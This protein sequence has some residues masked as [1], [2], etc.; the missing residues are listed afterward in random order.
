MLR[1]ALCGLAIGCS[2]LLWNDGDEP[3]KS[4]S[5]EKKSTQNN[6]EKSAAKLDGKKLS[7]DEQ[8]EAWLK[9][10]PV[11]ENPKGKLKQS[12]ALNALNRFQSQVLNSKAT[13]RA[14]TGEYWD[15]HGDGT[16]VCRRCNAPLYR[17]KDKFDSRCGWPSFDD[18]LPGLVTRIPDKDGLRIE[19]VCTNCGGHLGHV[20]SGEQFTAKNTRHCVNSASIQFISK[21]D[22]LP[23][24]VDP[25]EKSKKRGDKADKESAGKDKGIKAGD[26][27]GK[28]TTDGAADKARSQGS[29]KSG[30]DK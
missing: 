8:I 13:E 28:G 10:K 18:E 1:L 25:D 15:H 23:E 4:G 21:D 22:P 17:S 16:Y 26:A 5:N 14:F 12:S 11:A 30:E 29:S 20:F 9:T 6:A 2:A 27:P 3:T 7:H 19:I 24:V